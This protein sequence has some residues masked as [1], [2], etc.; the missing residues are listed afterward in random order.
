[1]NSDTGSSIDMMATPIRTPLL[2]SGGVLRNIYLKDETVQHT[3]AFKF[4]GVSRKIG[5]DITAGELITASTGNHGAAVAAV[6]AANGRPCRIFV[7]DSTPS[8]KLGRMTDAGASVSRVT[9]SYDACE[10][11][12]R[13]YAAETGGT[14]IPSFD[15]PE[16]IKGHAELFTEVVEDIGIPDIIIVPIG[17]GGL[18]AAAALTFRNHPN[19][20]VVGV[21]LAG[22]AAMKASLQARQRVEVDVPQGVAEGLCVRKV[23]ELPYRVASALNLSVVEVTVEQLRAACRVLWQDFGVRAELAGS[24]ALA[25]VLAHGISTRAKV[26]CVA[27]GGNIDDALWL[28][29]TSQHLEGNA[30]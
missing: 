29:I 13:K 24:A 6:G 8:I 10:K 27:S 11:T 25:A 23:G 1:M 18:A 12:A 2:N 9:G 28:D 20:R 21:E 26:A 15:D 3:G 16:I 4:R 5:Q 19:T 22:A 14:Y 17:G 30:A 7:P